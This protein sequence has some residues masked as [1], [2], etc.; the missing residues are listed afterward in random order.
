MQA[1]TRT[2]QTVC[3]AISVRLH[4]RRK[5]PQRYFGIDEVSIVVIVKPGVK[6]KPRLSSYATLKQ[7]KKRYPERPKACGKT[8][9][10]STTVF[11]FCSKALS[12]TQEALHTRRS[13]SC[14]LH[15]LSS[16]IGRGCAVSRP[17]FSVQQVAVAHTVH[18]LPDLGPFPLSPHY[19]SLVFALSKRTTRSSK[20]DLDPDPVQS[21][22]SLGSLLPQLE[23]AH[24]TQPQSFQERLAL[25]SNVALLLSSNL[26]LLFRSNSSSSR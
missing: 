5:Q 24:L 19:P 8:A 2:R 15:K 9:Q 26:A 4:R 6:A 3:L 22:Y 7:G 11:S 25:S 13:K 17:L 23:L 10:L 1:P 20:S 16:G 18:H 12:G 14:C 21:K